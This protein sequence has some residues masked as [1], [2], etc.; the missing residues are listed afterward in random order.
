MSENTTNRRRFLGA[1]GLAAV[2]TAGLALVPATAIAVDRGAAATADPS[3]GEPLD[4]GVDCDR[5]YQ[6]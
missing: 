2:A 4:A 3:T 6:P 5:E 1:A